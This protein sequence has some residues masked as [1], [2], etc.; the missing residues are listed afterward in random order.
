L[1]THWAAIA[2]FAFFALRSLGTCRTWGLFCHC[3]YFIVKG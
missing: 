1:L 2:F 3:A